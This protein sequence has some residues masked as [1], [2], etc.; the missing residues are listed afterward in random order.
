MRV[1]CPL[2]ETQNGTRTRPKILKFRIPGKTYEFERFPARHC[3]RSKI[4]RWA[5]F[6]V[7][8]PRV[9]LVFLEINSYKYIR[10]IY[11]GVACS[12]R[13]GNLIN[14]KHCF[15]RIDIDVQSVPKG[16]LTTKLAPSEV[17][18]GVKSRISLVF[19]CGT[20]I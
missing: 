19:P 1:R 14:R 3:H 4:A 9:S 20:L 2:P 11:R 17:G 16:D 10:E 7:Q 18:A 12:D 15:R 5:S 13:S 8:K 6:C